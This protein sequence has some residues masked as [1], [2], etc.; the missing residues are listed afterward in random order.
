MNTD[1]HEH[2]LGQTENIK[3]IILVQGEFHWFPNDGWTF[4]YFLLEQ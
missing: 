3:G 4:E 1:F 2:F